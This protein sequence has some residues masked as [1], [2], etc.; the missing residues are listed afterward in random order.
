MVIGGLAYALAQSTTRKKLCSPAGVM[1]YSCMTSMPQQRQFKVL[2]FK[3]AVGAA[4]RHWIWIV[5]AQ[6]TRCCLSL[7]LGKAE[8]LQV[9]SMC[10]IAKTI[11]R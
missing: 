7:D 3:H 10:R 5:A 6:R 1:Q 8:I 9:P 11:A 2:H 4:P